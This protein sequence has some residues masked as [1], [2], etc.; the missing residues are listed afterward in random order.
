MADPLI[1]LCSDPLNATSPDQAFAAEALAA[2]QLAFRRLLIDH[3]ALDVQLNLERALRRVKTQE[4]GKALYRGWMMRAEAYGALYQAL[5]SRGIQLINRPEQYAACH[6]TPEAYPSIARW[7][8]QTTWVRNEE[9]EDRQVIMS[10]LTPFGSSA[11]V[12]KDWVKSQA[13]GYWDE[14]C[15]VPDASDRQT[16]DKIIARFREITGTLTGGIVFRKFYALSKINGETEEWRAFILDGR[17]LGSWPRFKGEADPPPIDL[18]NKIALAVPSRFVS[19][20]LARMAEGGWLLVEVGDGQVSSFPS[21]LSLPE[22]FRA[23][24]HTLA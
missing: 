9:L 2:E 14:A 4:P 6:H 3:D 7:A 19:A 13:Q 8:A 15:F 23:L 22:V 24:G 10:A 1:V 16:V 18:L 12:I 20:D 11:I 5:D 21:S 17:V